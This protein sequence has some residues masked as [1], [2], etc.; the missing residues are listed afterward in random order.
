[1]KPL[2]ELCRFIQSYFKS[3]PTCTKSELSKATA[4]RFSLTRERSVF[5][6]DGF[7]LRFSIARGTTFPNCV[8]SLSALHKYDHMPFVVCVLRTNRVELLLANSTFLSKISHSSHQLRIDNVRGTF[9]GH[10]IIQSYEGIDNKPK[11]FAELF[12]IHAQFSW[13]ENLRR[14]VEK[15]TAIV[16]TGK[17][18]EPSDHERRNILNAAKLASEL[19]RNPEYLA[20]GNE[21]TQL[22]NDNLEEILEAAAIENA[23]ERGDLLE[24]IITSAGSFHALDDVTRTLTLGTDLKIDI[25]TKILT[26][27]S[28]PKGYNVDKV[29]RELSSGNSVVSFFFVGI[30]VQSR[31]VVTCLVS[32]LDSSI[33]N[34]TRIQ[35]HWAG[36]KSRGVTQ[37]AGNLP[38]FKSN[39][40]ETIDIDKAQDFLQQLID[41][42]ASPV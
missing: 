7:A 34:A 30:N 42:P 33:L 39:F 38:I 32:I 13:D 40:S 3:N 24:N 20:V 11:N 22:V 6:G 23:K 14:L 29:L 18:F 12:E 26:L 37:L 4:D 15:T 16:P 31:L 41:I 27:V 21:L 9:L 10:D 28:S 17:R 8:L 25:K 36:R 2:S 1:M 35:F 5:R 19:S